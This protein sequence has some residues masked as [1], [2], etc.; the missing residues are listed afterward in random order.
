MDLH[1]S[2]MRIAEVFKD[3][4]SY[5]EI[6]DFRLKRQRFAA[7]HHIDQFRAQQIDT[8][9]LPNAAVQKWA[10]WLV[11]P[12]YVQNAKLGIGELSDPVRENQTPRPQDQIVRIGERRIEPAMSNLVK[13]V[14]FVHSCWN[15]IVWNVALSSISCRC[16][17]VLRRLSLG[18]LRSRRF[19]ASDLKKSFT[20]KF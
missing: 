12:A 16:R 10:V 14:G 17:F 19:K 7:G 4:G 13:L 20:A 18:T 3:L 15:F 11:A 8:H 5:H 2:P 9:V 1:S 6:E